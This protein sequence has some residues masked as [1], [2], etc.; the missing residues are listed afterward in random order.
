[1]LLATLAQKLLEEDPFVGGVLIDEV[2]AVRSSATIYV[3]PT[4]PITLKRGR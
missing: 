4:W 1:M 3:A 2:Q